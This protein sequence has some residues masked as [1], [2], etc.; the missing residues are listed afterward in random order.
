MPHLIIHLDLLTDRYVAGELKQREEAEWPPHPGRLFMAL[1]ATCF[2]TGADE[3]AVASLQWLEQQGAPE[4][5]C[6]A[7]QPRS[8]A[9]V[10]VPVNDKPGGG[11]ILQTA[12]GVT[13]SRQERTFPTTIPESSIVRMI[14]EIAE[15]QPVPIEALDQLCGEMIRLG[16]SSSLVRA[17]AMVRQERPK[18]EDGH[19]CW[20]PVDSGGETSLRV[21]AVGAWQRLIVDGKREA[22]DRFA[23]L[24]EQIDSAK[25]KQ[26]TALKKSFEEE[27]GIAYKQSVRPPEPTPATIRT[28]RSYRDEV[29]VASDQ[30]SVSQPRYLRSEMIVLCK[31]DGASFSLNDTLMLTRQL[32]N[33][34]LDRCQPQPAPDWISGHDANGLPTR[35]PHMA[36]VPLPYVGTRHADGHIMG[37]AVLTPLRV[38][39]A[40]VGRSLGSVMVDQRGEPKDINLRFRHHDAW[41]L[42]LE[43]RDEPAVTLREQTWLRP[44]RRWCSVTPIVLDRYPKTDRQKDPAAWREEVAKVIWKSCGYAGI[45]PP[46]QIEVSTTAFVRGVPRATPK[47]RR[48]QKSSAS[49]NQSMGDG[50]PPFVVSAS[51]PP[52]VQVH[53]RL[54]FAEP[55]AGPMLIGAGRFLGYGWFRPE[56]VQGEQR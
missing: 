31:H 37:M 40:Q 20:T 52:R 44:S 9:A 15:E 17:A 16:H 45:E 19:H 54:T 22:I 11:G 33:T 47:F 25:G 3:K 32:R 36:I 46:T 14:W 27:F 21:A 53:A 34:V 8:S 39:P 42:R 4:I 51:K 28:W 23:E 55:H 26:K 18:A 30:T 12:P 50:F 56:S 38:S 29:T 5:Q 1:A 24:S 13:R 10:Y 35:L 48:L 2:E 7:P 6:G 43:N 49:S 41:T